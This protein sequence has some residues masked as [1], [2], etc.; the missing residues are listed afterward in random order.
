MQWK[1]SSKES[2]DGWLIWDKADVKMGIT[3]H[4]QM[5]NRS[6]HQ[7]DITILNVYATDNELEI[8]EA[9]WIA[10]NGEMDNTFLYQ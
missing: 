1:Y 10:T 2:E 6:S 9:K 8:H 5:I 4:F 7:E 3:R